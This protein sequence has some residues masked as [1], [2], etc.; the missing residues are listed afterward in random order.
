MKKFLFVFVAAVIASGTAQASGSSGSMIIAEGFSESNSYNG[1]MPDLFYEWCDEI[2]FPTV[3]LEVVDVSK[4]KHLGYIHAWGKEFAFSGNSVQFKEFILYEFPEGQL[5]TI[6]QEG[7][8]PGGAFADPTLIPPK[9]GAVVLVGGAE[10]VVVGGT[11]KY[12]KAGGMYST[13][14]KV[15]ADGEG[16]FVYY[17]EL[18]I[19]FREV[20]I[21]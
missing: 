9:E 16:V 14:L 19:R 12:V 3:T 4:T 5:Y 20:L 15:E 17:D 11:G 7:G 13:R 6:S 2:C 18:Y 8:H 1:V 21:N 10:G